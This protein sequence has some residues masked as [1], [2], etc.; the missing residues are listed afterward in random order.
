MLTTKVFGQ[1]QNKTVTEYILTN[2]VGTKL[3][4]MDYGATWLGLTVP[5]SKGDLP[6]LLRTDLATYSKPDAYFGKTI[7]RA[8]GRIGANQYQIDKRIWQLPTNEGQTTLH[9]GPAGFSQQLWTAVRTTDDLVTFELMLSPKQDGF[10]GNLTTQVTY[11][12]T[13]DDQVVITATGMSDDGSLFNPTNH[14]YFNFNVTDAPITNHTVQ[15]HSHQRFELDSEKLPTGKLLRNHGTPF[16]FTAPQKLEPA[17]AKLTSTKE[18]GIDDVF[19]IDAHPANFPIVTVHCSDI[20]MQIFSN[21][22]ALV[23]Y[24]SNIA[25]LD[26]PLMGRSAMLHYGLVLEPQTAPSAIVDQKFGNIRLR[27]GQP[28]TTTWRYAFTY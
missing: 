3:S 25:E 18:R 11:Q 24:T 23:M 1:W 21:R 8:A 28:Q 22:N 27:P 14:A 26:L 19:L 12:L 9:G 5:S 20:T 13:E 16:D 17:L 4:V 2:K 10:Y 15:L 6:L 7:G